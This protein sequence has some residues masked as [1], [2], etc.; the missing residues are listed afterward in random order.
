MS[1]WSRLCPCSAPASSIIRDF[2]RWPP[3]PDELHECAT[4]FVQS[5]YREGT[6]RISPSFIESLADF[7]GNGMIQH[8]IGE[9]CHGLYRSGQKSREDGLG[10]DLGRHRG[11]GG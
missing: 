1:A 3:T 4:I 7:Y 6:H 10:G 2:P 5:Q 9:S 8:P 11:G